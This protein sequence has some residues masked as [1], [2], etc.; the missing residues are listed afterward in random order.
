MDVIGDYVTRPIIDIEISD[1]EKFENS[2]KLIALMDTGADISFIDKQLLKEFQFFRKT[3]KFLDDEQILYKAYFSIEDLFKSYCLFIGAK[4]L[5]NTNPKEKK[6]DMLLGRDFL[7]H[8]EM[9]YIGKE[10]KI[11]IEWFK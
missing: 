2:R 7:K 11:F 10:S 1:S 9:K 4:E 8:C 6:F 3:E 5:N